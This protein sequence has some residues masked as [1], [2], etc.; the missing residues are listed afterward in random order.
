[1]PLA[2]G[3]PLTRNGHCADA[4]PFAEKASQANERNASD[5]ES[6]AA[7]WLIIR[8]ITTLR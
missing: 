6:A 4:R 1:V 8:F 7:S 3:K 5:F 2:L